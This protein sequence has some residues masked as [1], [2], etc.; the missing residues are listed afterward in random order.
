MW[1]CGHEDEKRAVSLLVRY[2]RRGAPVI[3]EPGH[4]NRHA[5]HNRAEGHDAVGGVA[6]GPDTGR[7]AD[8][9]RDRKSVV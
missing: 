3:G 9:R 7:C 1:T 8:R 2:G 4:P 6:R 5:L